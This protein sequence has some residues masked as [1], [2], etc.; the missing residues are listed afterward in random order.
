MIRS[1]A[2]PISLKWPLL[3]IRVRFQSSHSWLPRLII[4][5]ILFSGYHWDSRCR[6]SV[7]FLAH[8]AN[9]STSEKRTF[10][11]SLEPGGVFQSE[12]SNGRSS[13]YT[14]IERKRIFTSYVS[15]K[16]IEVGYRTYISI[17]HGSKRA[18]SPRTLVR[19]LSR[20]AALLRLRGDLKLHI[21]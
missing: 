21:Q 10:G 6:H 11:E 4:C 19:A 5:Y 1:T 20:G 18:R 9:W 13:R 17:L 3:M 14:N 8:D 2:V 16:N 7:W 15:V 12:A